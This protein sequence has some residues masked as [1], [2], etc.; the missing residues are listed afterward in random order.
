MTEERG[1]REGGEKERT[2]SF[3]FHKPPMLSTLSAVHTDAEKRACLGE[4][5][6]EA[7]VALPSP[8]TIPLMNAELGRILFQEKG[9]I[10]CQEVG[11]GGEAEI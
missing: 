5:N 8:P 10:F 3:I 6:G 2:A 7:G 1:R 11:G 4:K 9:V